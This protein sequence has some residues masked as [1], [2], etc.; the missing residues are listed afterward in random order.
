MKPVAFH[1]DAATEFDAAI[2]FYEKQ[3]PGLGVDFRKDIEIAVQR[4]QTTPS[5]W[6]LYGKRTRRFLIRRF[7][8]LVIFRELSEEII[9]IA[10]AH[11]S[12]RPG[13]WHERT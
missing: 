2:R 10:V 3:L 5:R 8:Y 4:I 6:S 1:P 9:I 11:G 7:P 13:Y 12:R